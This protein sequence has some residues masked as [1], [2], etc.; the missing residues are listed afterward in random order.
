METGYYRERVKQCIKASFRCFIENIDTTRRNSV[1]ILNM[2]VV[3]RTRT[4]E[5][6][7]VPAKPNAKNTISTDKRFQELEIYTKIKLYRGNRRNK[8]YNISR[9]QRNS[10]TLFEIYEVPI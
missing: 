5:K 10:G 1:D 9:N 6:K 4:N 2:K 8:E 3:K 7:I